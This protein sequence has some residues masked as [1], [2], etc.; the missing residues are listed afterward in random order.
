MN[1]QMPDFSKVADA[2]TGQV[3][4]LTM[5]AMPDFNRMDLSHPRPI[6]QV[7]VD[8]QDMTD[9]FKPRLMDLTLTDLRGMEA[10]TLDITLDDSDGLLDLPPR[11]AI[12]QLQ[13]GWSDSGLTDKGQYVVD[14]L[15]HTGAPDQLIIRARSADL[16]DGLTTKKER[17][18]AN[19]TLASII[20]KVAEESL[21]Q[22]VVG[23]DFNGVG[24][25]HL[26]QQ[27]ESDANML[28]RLAQQY[29]AICTVKNKT[30]LFFKPGKAMSVSGKPLPVF[31]IN[32]TD[33]DRHRFS[34][35]DRNHYVAVRA[36][37][38]DSRAGKKGEVI[39]DGKSAKHAQEAAAAGIKT[40][41]TTYSTNKKA[42]LATKDAWKKA[43]A[44]GENPKLIQA[45][46][47][48]KKTG[49]EAV[50]TF[51]GKK[52]AEQK[53]LTGEPRTP[54]TIEASANNIKTLRH[55]YATQHNAAVAA[56]A[57]YERLQRGL[58]TLSITLAR[59]M[60][61]IFPEC[62]VKLQGWKTQIDEAS[63]LSSKVTHRLNGSG[64]YVTEV[65]S[66]LREII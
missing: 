49:K 23:E 12:V 42:A 51:D 61:M 19:T 35:A 48:E 45:Q 20:A 52:T 8:G 28:T 63:W 64:G 31:E 43:K 10:D 26:A 40:L 58:A 41:S 14:E 54:R 3:S 47:R 7:V 39:F 13:L 36:Q 4:G 5:P 21:L 38:Y 6:Y 53:E 15:E 30:L 60:P 33:G 18:W 55:T 37:Y 65:E 11:G 50:V 22:Y 17:S 44:L 32:R 46:Y 62:P 16:R 25:E 27:Y 59:G 57:E 56:K 24:I 2:V 9:V 34:V 1:V 66:E 29:G